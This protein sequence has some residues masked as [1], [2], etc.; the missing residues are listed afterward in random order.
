VQRTSY[1]DVWQRTGSAAA[2]RRH[3][4]LSRDPAKRSASCASA[5]R[6]AATAGPGARIAYAEYPTVVQV[7][8][9]RNVSYGWEPVG[10]GD[11]IAATPGSYTAVITL[12]VAGRYAAWIRASV[13]RRVSITVDGKPIG[14]VRWKQSYPGQYEPLET[15]T[16]PAGRHVVRVVRG[17][18]SPLPGTGNDIG[19][20]FT[21]LV[22]PVAFAA[23]DPVPAVRTAPAS[24]AGAL[25]RGPRELDWIEVLRK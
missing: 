5:V 19:A 18:G 22:G 15:V 6:S 10:T 1:Y 14:S 4:P 7:D 9:L 23:V 20:Y 12:P 24:E 8:R 11:Y 16:L 17:G 3:I 25:C 13:G 2:I 21:T